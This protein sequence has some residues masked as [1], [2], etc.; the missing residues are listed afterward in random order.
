[1]PSNNFQN[2]SRTSSTILLDQIREAQLQDEEL[3]KIRNEVQ[4]GKQEE[5][6]I[7]KDGTVLL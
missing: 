7:S 4:E 3:T 5:F 1:M 2:A 6:S